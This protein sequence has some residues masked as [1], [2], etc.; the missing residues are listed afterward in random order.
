MYNPHFVQLHFC[1]ETNKTISELAI[2]S[3]WGGGQTYTRRS[4]V[5]I[6]DSPVLLISAGFYFL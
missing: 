6:F 3:Q 1:T 5:E 2:H 4:L